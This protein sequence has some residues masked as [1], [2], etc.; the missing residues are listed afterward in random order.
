MG[1]GD[2]LVE[3]QLMTRRGRRATFPVTDADVR[4]GQRAGLTQVS[5]WRFVV[6]V[7]GGATRVFDLS[8]WG[9]PTFTASILQPVLEMVRR[10]GPAPLGATLQSKIL[11]LRRFWRFLAERGQHLSKIEDVTADLLDRYEVVREQSDV[12]F[13][14]G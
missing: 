12:R 11:N 6:V 7:D 2:G 4:E 9:L 3:S 1:A 5:P 10:M 13:G 14:A 8:E